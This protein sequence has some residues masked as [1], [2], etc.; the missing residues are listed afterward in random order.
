MEHDDNY[1]HRR[2]RRDADEDDNRDDEDIIIRPMI[3]RE[4]RYYYEAEILADKLLGLD[5]DA[6]DE[7]P[8]GGGTAGIAGNRNNS[9]PLL[10]DEWKSVLKSIL[11]VSSGMVAAALFGTVLASDA[12]RRI[13][14]WVWSSVTPHLVPSPASL[15]VIK[16]SVR[17]YT[18]QA[19][20]L[21]HS[22]PYALRH[23]NRVKLPPMLPFLAR[24]LRKCVILEAWRHIWLQVYKLTRYVRRS[25]TLFNAKRAYVRLFPAWIRR[26]VKN[27][28][29]SLVQAQVAGAVGDLIGSASF[30]GAIWS[31][32]GGD[33]GGGG[34]GTI[35]DDVAAAGGDGVDFISAAMDSS[36]EGGDAIVEA[37]SECAESAAGAVAETMV[38]EGLMDALIVEV[39]G[40][41]S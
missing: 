11:V 36:G 30:E 8:C 1:R 38:A 14:S 7:S 22:A 10:P 33:G 20:A 18:L 5:D 21:W 25:M 28:F 26:G 2:D 17:G 31:S 37:L 39:V 34:G 12:T 6:D 24:L 15:D 13:V 40:E 41:M 32:D 27:I 35:V 16:S 23:I 19:Q 29:Q 3:R 4:R 9:S